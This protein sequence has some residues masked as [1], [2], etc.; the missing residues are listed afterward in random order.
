MQSMHGIKWNGNIITNGH[1][2]QALREAILYYYKVRLPSQHLQERIRKM[3]TASSHA[4]IQTGYHHKRSLGLTA[5][6]LLHIHR[7][8][9]SL[10][11]NCYHSSTSHAYVLQTGHDI[12]RV[13]QGS[14]TYGMRHSLLSNYFILFFNIFLPDQGRYIVTNMCNCTHIWL[15]ADCIWIT[16]AT[17]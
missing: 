15:R 14:Q 7:V 6:S 1:K 5:I 9:S 4:K 8:P 2:I 10:I 3:R 11:S 17:E 13:Q 12:N 16:T